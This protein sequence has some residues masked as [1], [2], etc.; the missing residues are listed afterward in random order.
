MQDPRH[1]EDGHIQN[2]SGAEALEKLKELADGTCM[3]TTFTTS[4]PAPSRPMALQGVDDAGV[5]YFLSAASS[6]KN[7]EVEADPAVQLFFCKEGS[8]EFLSLYGSAT[9]S[10]DRAKIEAYWTPFAKAWFQG[11]KD[12]PDLTVIS[13]KPENC[14]YWDTKNN[15]AVALIKI[16]ASLVTGKTMDD[17]VEGELTV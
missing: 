15:R 6:N 2:L 11:G 1:D 5:L 16:A 13:V 3:F 4:R 10:R 14:R 9:I 7:K 17:G 8:S 12:D